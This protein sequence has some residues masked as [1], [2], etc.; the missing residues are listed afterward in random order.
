MP[1]GARARGRLD[2]RHVIGARPTA[3][4]TGIRADT[5]PSTITTAITIVAALAS[6]ANR[7]QTRPP[8]YAAANPITIAEYAE[9]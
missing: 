8:M 7:A 6:C 1:A 2:H 5:T 3:T 4:S 9:G